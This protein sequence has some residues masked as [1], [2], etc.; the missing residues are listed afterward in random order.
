M[1]RIE[2][3]GPRLDVILADP[4]RLNAMSGS[5]WR[6][7]AEIGAAPPEGTRVIVLRAD[8]PSFSAGLDRRV[9]TGQIKPGLAEL[10]ALGDRKLDEVIASYQEG[11]TIWRESEAIVIAAIQ[12]YAIGAGF[13]LAL[14]ADLRIAAE[15]AQ[16]A[17]R[18]TS[19]GLVPD[20]AGTEPLL[21]LV[22]YSRALEICVSGR[23]VPAAE[24]LALGIVSATAPVDSLMSVVDATVD[25]IL[26]MPDSSVRATKRVLA[27]VANERRDDQRAIE[28]AAQGDLLRALIR[29][30]S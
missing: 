10:A 2:H 9:M 24:A 26:A 6:T 29:G 14:A 22:G 25:A 21:D 12:G 30:T 17:M 8:G 5:T 15:D 20:L 3:A 27:K 11:F 19:L 18:E 28:R 7:L 1:I 4:E 13:Q 16:F 23:M